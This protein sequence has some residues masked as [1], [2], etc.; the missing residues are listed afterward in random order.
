MYEYIKGNVAY[1]ALD[2]VVLD[3]HGI[4]YKILTSEYTAT[5]CKTN[6]EVCLFTD[7][8]VREDYMGLCGFIDRDEQKVFQLLTTISG[9][10]PKVAL[11]VLSKIIYTDLTRAILMG[12]V[13]S[14]QKAPGIGTKT[15]QRIV[16]EL[17]DKISKSLENVPLPLEMAMED[18]KNMTHEQNMK[19]A[20]DAM[21]QLGYKA[22][23]VEKIFAA[24]GKPK[25]TVE[26]LIKQALSMISI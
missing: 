16:L 12:D 3:H 24:I 10:G 6:E 17:K 1:R 2:Y 19:D 26:D 15:A 9:I 13:K 18:V 25:G 23:D 20:M 4:G 22:S 8:I 11:S 5:K 7:L 21:M 14:L